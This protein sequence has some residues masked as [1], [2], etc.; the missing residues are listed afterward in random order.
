MWSLSE[1]HEKENA[2]QSSANSILQCVVPTGKG[3]T[4]LMCSKE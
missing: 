1:T 2:K 3:R 4:S